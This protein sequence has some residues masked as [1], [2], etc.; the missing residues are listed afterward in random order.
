MKIRPHADPYPPDPEAQRMT[1][2]ARRQ[3]RG[4]LP[5]PDRRGFYLRQLG[6]EDVLPA[7]DLPWPER[8]HPPIVHRRTP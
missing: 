7:D 5:I 4:R 8:D 3:K 6:L 1:A 2:R